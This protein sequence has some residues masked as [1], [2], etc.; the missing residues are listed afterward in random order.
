[1]TIES[2]RQYAVLDGDSLA[3]LWLEID[4]LRD[5]RD[6]M[7]A[8]LAEWDKGMYDGRDFLRRV[9]LVLHGDAGLT[10]VSRE[11]TP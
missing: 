11:T 7:R 6:T 4:G 2:L 3:A 10:V 5:E 1:M 8:L 9:R